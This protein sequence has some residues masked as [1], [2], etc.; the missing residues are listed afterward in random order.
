MTLPSSRN[1]TVVDGT[2]PVLASLLNDLQDAII[3]GKHGDLS[4][5]IHPSELRSA[6]AYSEDYTEIAGS[7][8]ATVGIPVIPGQ[9]L[10][11][12]TVAR[13]GPASA[14]HDMTVKLRK[15]TA[16]GAGSYLVNAA[17]NNLANAWADGTFNID[18]DYVVAAGEMFQL[19]F[20]TPA[21]A[22]NIRIG[23]IRI[24]RDKP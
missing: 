15:T 19:Q 21:Q 12:I 4:L 2:T 23:S 7:L 18:P 3:G 1:Y 5:I 13:W 17:D 11:S 24:L 16:A 14:D 10:K 8:T 22:S 9:R 6:T 20:V